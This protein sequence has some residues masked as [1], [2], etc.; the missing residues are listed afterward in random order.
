MFVHIVDPLVALLFV[1]PINHIVE[2]LPDPTELETLLAPH[3]LD[4]FVQGLEIGYNPH[5]VGQRQHWSK[6]LGLVT[7]WLRQ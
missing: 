1:L 4:R 2:R 5:K 6:R 7:D 3:N